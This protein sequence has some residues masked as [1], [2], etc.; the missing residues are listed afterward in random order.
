MQL[1]ADFSERV[2]L[3][4]NDLSWEASP[5]VGVH[6][7]KLDR[8]GDEVGRVTSIVRYDAG[9][10]FSVHTHN[11]GEEFL[12]LEGTFSDETGDYPAGTYVR[13][14]IGTSHA[15][16]SVE[17]CVIFVKLHQFDAQD[18]EQF[19][20]DTNDAQF[21]P[22]MKPG[23]SVLSLH[24]FGS[25][26]SALVRWAPGTEFTPHTHFGGE[27]ILVLEGVFS[28]EFGDYPKGS[29]IRSPHGSKHQPFSRE[30]C[31]IYVKTGHL[32]AN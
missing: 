14:P 9:S 6:R 21:R 24:T 28:D 5:S 22:G 32:P 30:G 2:T 7:R 12:V 27:E 16:H 31:L 11:G 3:Q 8:M 1:H 26:S 15:P 19:S 17:G 18:V 13:N 20:I 4:T 25:E 10:A 29:W 23:L